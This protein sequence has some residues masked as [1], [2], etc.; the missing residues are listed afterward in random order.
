MD[1]IY[2]DNSASAVPCAEALKTFAE[3]A[4]I[5]A[6]P[7]S[8]H[9]P[10]LASRRLIE[11]ARR[12][13]AFA[14]RCMPEE[15]F[16]TSGGTE[17][18]NIAVRSCA[19]K[20][21]HAGGVI[22][23]TKAEHPSVAQSVA[24]LEREGFRPVYISARGGGPDYAELENAL[25]AE[26]VCL[27]ALMQ[28]NNQNGAVTDLKKVRE[29]ITASA[30]KALFHS[31][32]VQ[33]FLKLP[34][35]TAGYAAKYCDTASFS[36]H[37]IGGIKGSGAL[38]V[39]KGLVLPGL[40]CGGEQENGVRPGTENLPG[41]CAFAKAASLFGAEKRKR[42][43]EL[44][45][46]LVSSLREKLGENI[47]IAEPEPHIDSLVNISLKNVKSEVALNRLNSLG[48]CVSSSS[49]CSSKAKTNTALAALGYGAAYDMS[50]IR[51]GISPQNT[52]SEIDAL[53]SGLS[54]C[55]SFRIKGK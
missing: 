41:I 20:N 30:S 6:N 53:V 5:Y 45:E 3:T 36:A 44:R 35:E 39:R 10:G 33:A 48:I 37:K 29:C 50:A 12:E 23:T 43:F 49:A 2:F 46:Y 16:F 24:S 34:D 42:L 11:D 27:V 17:S 25:K 21:R 14:V 38:F 52:E 26:K 51:I 1:V 54:E 32:C 13:L 15:L 8:P 9:S 19:H 22:V 55:L 18:N 7:S 40:F 47:E 28:A 31:D 4:G